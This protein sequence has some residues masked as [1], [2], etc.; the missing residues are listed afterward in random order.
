ML[1]GIDSR[2]FSSPSSNSKTLVG[3]LD[4]LFDSENS[5]KIGTNVVAFSNFPVIILLNVYTGDFSIFKAE[6]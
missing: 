2:D 6:Y 3:L 4:P 5:I 1:S